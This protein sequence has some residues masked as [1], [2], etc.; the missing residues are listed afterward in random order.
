[1]RDAYASRCPILK[2]CGLGARYSFFFQFI[3]RLFSDNWGNNKP[4]HRL[5]S[6]VRKMGVTALTIEDLIPNQE[7]L[8]EQADLQRFHQRP[9]RTRARRVSFFRT[10]SRDWRGIPDREFL[11]YAVVLVHRLGRRKPLAHILEAVVREPAIFLRAQN[12]VLYPETVGNYYPHCVREFKSAVGT[13][14]DHKEF[15]VRGAFFCQQNGRTHVCAHAA[16]RMAV[17]SSPTLALRR[18]LTNRRIND[19][20]GIDHV[21][22]RADDGLSSQQIQKVVSRLNR[23]CHTA[24]FNERPRVDYAA[25]V[26]PLVESR[27]PVI[28]GIEGPSEPHVVAVLGH[29][30]N[31]DRWAPEAR[32]GYGCLPMSQHM[33]SAAWAD[34]FIINDDNYGMSI[35]LPAETVQNFLV[36]QFNPNLHAAMA[37]GIVPPRVRIHGYLAEQSAARIAF[38]I[39]NAISPAPRNKWLVY[40]QDLIREALK[41]MRSGRSPTRTIVC[42]TLLMDRDGYARHLGVTT[43]SDA[44]A[45]TEA[46]KRDLR[47]RLPRIFW[48]TEI[49]LPDLYTANKHKLGDIV[50]SANPTRRHIETGAS[51]VFCWLP[52]LAIMRKEGRLRSFPWSL[53]GH[54]PLIRHGGGQV[55]ALEW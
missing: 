41:A 15:R 20:L 18:K 36:P 29:T 1:M 3:K 17:N 48:L 45:L 12:G 9:V 54:I 22:R 33:S 51:I 11:G 14:D 38:G 21:T 23:R 31:S 39:V 44:N 34:H 13:R 8:N 32:Q 16:L 27:L 35:T 53:T 28:L 37:I 26:Y 2:P 24:D 19:L 30:V 40:L 25:F 52:G 43:D 4:L 10:T 55:P 50:S 42:R 5:C 47:K 49:S 7:I 6:L 46:E